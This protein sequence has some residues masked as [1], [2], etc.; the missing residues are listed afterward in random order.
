MS[1]RKLLNCCA[2]L[3]VILLPAS[4][5]LATGVDCNRVHD[6]VAQTICTHRDLL[7]WDGQLSMAYA[8]ALA[9]DPTRANDL[10]NDEIN[11][12]GDRNREIWWRSAAERQ[13]PSL[14]T[15]DSALVHVYQQRIAFLRNVDNPDATHDLPL[16]A[17]LLGAAK[18]LPA[19]TSDVMKSL[20]A[21]GVVVLPTPHDADRNS[22]DREISML[23]AAPDL[24]LRN[25]LKDFNRGFF[26]VVYLPSAGL[27]GAFT[28]QG[29]ADCQYW[30]VFR[31]Q[32]NATVLVGGQVGEL[33]GTCTRD[34][35]STGYL[36]SI[37]GQPVAINVT[38]PPALPNVTDLQWRR[39]LGGSRW[40]A[41]TRIRLRYGYVLHTSN[42]NDCPGASPQCAL[43][44]APAM[45]AAQRYVHDPW[46]L[47]R[48][49]AAD[50]D[51]RQMQ[52]FAPG[53]T[54]WADCSYPAWFKAH[55]DGRLVVAG[56]SESHMG[57]HPG[58]GFLSVG[59]WGMRSDNKHW[60]SAIDTITAKRTHLLA[61]ALVP[62]SKGL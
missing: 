40:S 37:D 38:Y 32:G 52:A 48:P 13:F 8:A 16:A 17:R 33:S 12:I 24:S 18:A 56:I 5:A 20:A 46:D 51:F 7:A 55:L 61:A 45:W 2:L 11:W 25:A 31:K 4:H 47:D 6:P 53:H 49:T 58:N 43:T 35:G 57:C 62:P 9:R 30:V 29:T 21:A 59:F 1:T 22:V 15:S 34:G 39:W 3:A 41:P 28:I 50:A 27:G 10:K 60:W 42:E 26:T 44:H 54:S 19:D 36:A 14:P 23:A